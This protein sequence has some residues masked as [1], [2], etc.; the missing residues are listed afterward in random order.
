MTVLVEYTH[1]DSHTLKHTQLVDIITVSRYYV[2]CYSF[3]G[4]L[5]HTVMTVISWAS[6]NDVTM[7]HITMWTLTLSNIQLLN[8]DVLG[9]IEGIQ[10][11]GRH[12][13]LMEV[14][15]VNKPPT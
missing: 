2:H 12:P 3:T 7:I 13:A 5:L 8:R 6:H 1:T 14:V 15:H 11:S 9:T 10:V 4:L